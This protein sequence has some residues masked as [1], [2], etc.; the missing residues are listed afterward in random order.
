MQSRKSIWSYKQLKSEIYQETASIC[1]IYKYKQ[2]KA[3]KQSEVTLTISLICRTIGT[4]GLKP[5]NADCKQYQNQTFSPLH[6]LSLNWLL[7]R[8]QKWFW[9]KTLFPYPS[10]FIKNFIIF[11]CHRFYTHLAIPIRTSCRHDLPE[12]SQATATLLRLH[13]LNQYH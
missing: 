11:L 6:H 7:P 9:S 3:K 8:N 12:E 2:N 10:Y 13:C 1:R 4:S 5:Q